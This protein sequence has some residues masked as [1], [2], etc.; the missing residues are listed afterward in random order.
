[1]KHQRYEFENT[2]W[3]KITLVDRELTAGKSKPWSI[4]EASIA[5]P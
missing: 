1:M 5:L 2:F 4:S 3:I